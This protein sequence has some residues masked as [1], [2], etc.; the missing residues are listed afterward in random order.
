MSTDAQAQA[1]L[2]THGESPWQRVIGDGL[3]EAQA[4]LAQPAADGA[5]P[6]QQGWQIVG[7]AFESGMRALQA[8]R[9]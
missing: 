8:M 2:A 7:R 4:I 6:A 3:R 1:D 9:V 5:E